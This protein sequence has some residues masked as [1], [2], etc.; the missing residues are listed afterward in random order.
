M[1]M[2]LVRLE[3][4]TE[5]RQI[6]QTI[7]KDSSYGYYSMLANYRL[8]SLPTT[9]APAQTNAV[10]QVIAVAKADSNEPNPMCSA[11]NWR[12]KQKN[13]LQPI[14]AKLTEPIQ[15]QQKAKR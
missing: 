13:K 8:E 14:T 3:R 12:R 5:A 4:F 6:L 9:P 7:A 10:K 1:A 2:S 15:K 11:H